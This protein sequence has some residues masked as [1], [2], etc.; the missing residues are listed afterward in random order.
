MT[1]SQTCAIPQ[2]QSGAESV[3]PDLFDTPLA[4]LLNAFDVEL[5]DSSITDAGFFGA[6]VERRDGTRILSMPVGRSFFEQ[7]TAARMLL[8][9]GLGLDAPPVPTPLEVGVL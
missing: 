3:T 5:V 4:D 2:Q 6:L 8:A 1:V 9:E 7:D